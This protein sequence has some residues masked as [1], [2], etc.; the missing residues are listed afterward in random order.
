MTVSVS[1]SFQQFPQSIYSGLEIK[2]TRRYNGAPNMELRK[3]KKFT[4][5]LTSL[6]C[7]GVTHPDF[8]LC[9]HVCKIA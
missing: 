1:P 9:A 7:T 3:G 2:T 6:L 5:E 4:N 8:H